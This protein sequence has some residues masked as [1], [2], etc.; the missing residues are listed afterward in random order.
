MEGAE[1]SEKAA[2]R[3]RRAPPM[4]R[5]DEAAA[6]LDSEESEAVGPPEPVGK[7]NGPTLFIKLTL[8]CPDGTHKPVRVLCDTA[9]GADIVN[10]D[11]ARDLQKRGV[12]WGESGG[13][14]KVLGGGIVNPEGSLRILCSSEGSDLQLPR[15]L[16]FV[17]EPHIVHE[18]PADLILGYPT[19]QGVGLLPVLLQEDQFSAE[20]ESA[21][22]VSE[23]DNDDDLWAGQDPVRDHAQQTSC[24]HEDADL[25]H[26]VCPDLDR[27]KYKMPKIGGPWWQRLKLAH[28]CVKYKEVF[29]PVAY[30]GSKLPPMDIKLKRDKDGNEMHPPPAKV[31][32]FAPWITDLIKQD[33]DMRISNGWYRKGTSRY[34]SPIVP[35]KQPNKGPNARR[36]CVDFY[37]PN[38]CSEEIK[39]PVKNQAEVTARLA[40]SAQ[41]LQ[42]NRLSEGISSSQI[43]PFCTGAVSLCYIIWS[44]HTTHC[45]LRISWSASILYNDADRRSVSRT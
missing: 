3:V 15:P 13:Q 39:Y 44:V 45:T 35:A 29:G 2:K 33:I 27:V 32:R 14:L 24:A 41:V 9:S 5:E 7:V 43:D 12:S 4:Y 30:G 22:E 21:E 40:G 28:L 31:R 17:C 11:L 6:E 16:N 26:E 38:Q 36:I 8:V 34:A 1:G 19:L 37:G 18:T 10:L 42:H 25:W 23:L 20:T